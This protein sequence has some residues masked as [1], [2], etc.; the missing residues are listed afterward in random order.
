MP[1]PAL[2]SSRFRHRKISVKQRLRVYKCH[3]LKDFDQD[4]NSVQNAQHQQRELIE[5]ETGVEKHEEKEEHLYKI[6]QSN[7]LRENKKDLYIPTPDASKTWEEYDKFYQGKFTE[8]SS[9]I[10]FSA[11]LEDCCG[12]L[13]NMDERDEEFLN[14][15]NASVKNSKSK[16]SEDEFELIMSN[17]ESSIR[18]RQPFLS[19]DPESI[20]SF[21]DLKPTILKNDVGDV[22][23]KNQLAKE[24]GMVEDEPFITT[25]DSKQCVEHPSRSISVL[26]ELFG[27]TVYDYWKERKIERD[28]DDI[29]PHLKSERNSDKDDNDP[30]VCF[31]R[32][33]VRQPRK[34]RRVD[35]QNSQK[36]R[37]LYQQLEYT[38]DLAL[39]VAM[40]ERISLK[41]LQNDMSIFDTRCQVKSIK[42]KL[43]ISGDDEE[44]FTV[45]RPR[46]VSSV[47]TLQQQLQAAIATSDSSIKKSKALKA[48]KSQKYADSDLDE[49]HLPDGKKKGTKQPGQ[50]QKD[51]SQNQQQ[52]D[53]T[54]QSSATSAKQQQQQQLQQQAQS[55]SQVYV[56]LPSSKIPDIVLDDVGKLLHSK[57]KNTRK[58]VEDRMQKRKHEDGDTFFN[59]TDDPYNPVFEVSIPKEL[60]PTDAPFSSVAGS[61]FEVE[62]SFYSSNLQDYI[63]GTAPDISLFNEDGELLDNN[64]YKKLEMFSP[65]EKDLHLNSKELPISFRRR[66]GRCN[67]EYI[68]QKRSD[69]NINDMLSEM[70]DLDSIK[71]QENENEVI[72]VY[73]SKLDEL[74]RL[75]Y[76]WRND[77]MFNL[78]GSKF[79]NEPAKLNQISNETQVIR[80]GTMLG[81]KSYEQLRDATMKYRQEQI[82]RRKK[83]NA[84]QQQANSR[85]QQN[86]YTHQN[87]NSQSVSSVSSS[88]SSPQPSSQSV[89]R[90]SIQPASKPPKKRATPSAVA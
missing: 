11:Q 68:D 73:D 7:Q 26:V 52:E 60:D 25:F 32:R 58:F 20:L 22:G 12:S 87:G 63:T 53:S 50:K 65:F 16:I 15:L 23:V 88:Q 46:L 82:I 77:S 74:S 3:E 28:G 76:K 70:L 78:Y 29:F 84:I 42:R 44:L 61:K 36:L 83:L 64:K 4:D 72:N 2:D 67:L 6:L 75:H 40:R 37:L 30:Y 13:Y 19:M 14:K 62:R 21:V 17:L 33:E 38:K 49:K 27:S 89:E 35:V 55:A 90:K 1:A 31:R 66:R 57:E 69:R 86:N 80:F 18:E 8:P 10:Q 34:T 85:A 47:V 45:K 39:R 43:G 9:Y 59:L 54:Q 56:K 48:S 81:S 5:I 79:S 71:K 51:Q 24:L 41:Q